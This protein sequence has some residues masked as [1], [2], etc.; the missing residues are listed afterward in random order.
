MVW[1]EKQPEGP[2]TEAQMRLLEAR[3]GRFKVIVIP[4]ESR[5][6]YVTIDPNDLRRKTVVVHM[7]KTTQL[8]ADFLQEQ[9]D[10]AQMGFVSQAI[11]FH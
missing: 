7:P 11:S 8:V 3:A 10:L 6:L 1:D 4:L 2:L 9:P 5:R